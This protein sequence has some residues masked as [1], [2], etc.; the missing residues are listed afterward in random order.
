MIDGLSKDLI[1]KLSPANIEDLKDLSYLPR[2][3]NPIGESNNHL[4]S[5]CAN[6]MTTI[7]VNH[8]FTKI[9]STLRDKTRIIFYINNFETVLFKGIDSP[10]CPYCSD[11][12]ALRFENSLLKKRVAKLEKIIHNRESE[13][14]ENK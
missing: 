2:Q 3:E 7:W 4:C 11:V 12:A 10:D 6:F 8:M 14:K 9:P 5:T 1:E 13:E